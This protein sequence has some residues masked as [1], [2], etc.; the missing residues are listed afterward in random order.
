MGGAGGASWG[1][2]LSL[3]AETLGQRWLTRRCPPLREI[4]P[5]GADLSG[6]TAVVTG[7]TSGI[8]TTTAGELM[9]RGCHGE[10]HRAP[11]APAPRFAPAVDAAQTFAAILG[12]EPE[13]AAAYGG[14][15][16]AHIAMDD[17]DQAEA[18][19]NGR[20]PE[21]LTAG[22]LRRLPDLPLDWTEQRRA[23]GFDYRP[24]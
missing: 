1:E 9:R 18:I 19:L 23:L 16:R 24:N 5:G 10:E 21:T 4:A 14:L 12:E 13:N 3:T 15:V 7:P 22:S 20:Q 17:L 2:W 8:G 6:H 11:S